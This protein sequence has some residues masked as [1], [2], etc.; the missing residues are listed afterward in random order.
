MRHVPKASAHRRWLLAGVTVA[1]V[2]IAATGCGGG[3]SAGPESSSASGSTPGSSVLDVDRDTDRVMNPRSD[4]DSDAVPTKGY[5]AGAAETQAISTLI[6]RYYAAA[7]AGD[8]EKA[9]S[10]TY[11]LTAEMIVEEHRH[12]GSA[13]LRGSTCA[14]VASE[15]FK[16]RHR[17]LDE[18]LATLQVAWVRLVAKRGLARVRFGATRE[19]AVFVHREG[20]A[21]KM[22][23]LL[24]GGAP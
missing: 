5:P 7:D 20:N 6:R 3:A 21:W 13:S 1:F 19:R 8:G 16:Q 10:L 11:W 23:V 22:S 18:D 24:D 14:Q 2:T 15:L 17:E 4:P 9:C 12:K